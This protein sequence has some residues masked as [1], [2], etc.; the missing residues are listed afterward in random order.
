MSRHLSDDAD[1]LAP[2]HPPPAA[3]I[4]LGEAAAGCR[5]CANPVAARLLV[6]MRVPMP[7]SSSKASP[8]PPPPPNPS[9]GGCCCCVSSPPP[10]AV[11]VGSTVVTAARTARAAAVETVDVSP[12]WVSTPA[13]VTMT[14]V[15]TT[16]AGVSS[17]MFAA[18][19]VVSLLLLLLLGQR[20]GS[21]AP[22]V[23]D[24]AN[25]AL[26]GEVRTGFESPMSCSRIALKRITESWEAE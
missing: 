4:V 12:R 17:S 3:A 15:T 23:D 24:A 2:P 5:R 20:V 1:A 26:F 16:P 10:S 19:V 7:C 21:A 25:K 22:L 11:P 6:P 14:P 18:V 9:C 8:T 13:A